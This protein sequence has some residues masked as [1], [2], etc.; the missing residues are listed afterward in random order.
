MKIKISH[1]KKDCPFN[2][3]NHNCWLVQKLTGYV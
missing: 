1:P 2:T 3:M